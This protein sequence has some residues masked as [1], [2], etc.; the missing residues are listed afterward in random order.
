MATSS[1]QRL[2]VAT[3]ALSQQTQHSQASALLLIKRRM[4]AWQV[5]VYITQAFAS[6]QRDP[7]PC[8][9]ACKGAAPSAWHLCEHQHH[10]G[11]RHVCRCHGDDYARAKP[12][13]IQRYRHAAHVCANR[14][15]ALAALPN[16]TDWFCRL[17]ATCC[18]VAWELSVQLCGHMVAEYWWHRLMHTR[19][20]VA[21]CMEWPGLVEA[22]FLVRCLGQ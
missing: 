9:R 15:Q 10:Y 3:S 19:Y 13:A 17:R 11:V 12:D 1:C 21:L 16:E 6:L 8:H 5:S 22:A 4:L 14:F 7:L 20:L 18:R 2:R